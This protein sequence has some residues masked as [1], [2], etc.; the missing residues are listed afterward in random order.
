MKIKYFEYIAIWLSVFLA[1]IFIGNAAR[2]YSIRNGA[3]EFT[4]NVG[5]LV[6][7]AED[8]LAYGE[9]ST[10]TSASTYTKF[11][12][13]LDYDPTQSSNPDSLFISFSL[14]NP[15]FGGEPNSYVLIDDLV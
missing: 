14:G 15:N 9:F 3:D 6:S 7:N 1:C 12:I 11:E 13:S 5:T 2:E 8:I 4:I 10:T